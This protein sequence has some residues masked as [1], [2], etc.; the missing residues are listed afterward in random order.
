MGST[1]TVAIKPNNKCCN[2]L[3]YSDN[4]CLARSV[5]R[6]CGGRYAPRDRV[7]LDSPAVA[8]E[9]ATGT[10]PA[11]GKPKPTPPRKDR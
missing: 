5:P 2:C 4:H 3:N 11:A 8:G 1:V 7:L 6:F 9:G 10:E